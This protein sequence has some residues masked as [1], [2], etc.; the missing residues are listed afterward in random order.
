M[1]NKTYLI[2]SSVLIGAIVGLGNYFEYSLSERIIA[3]IV[4]G[5]SFDLLYKKK[6]KK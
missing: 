5:Y 4:V 3:V 6:L 1:T 2:I